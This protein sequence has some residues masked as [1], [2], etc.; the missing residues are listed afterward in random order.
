MTPRELRAAWDEAADTL[1]P[2]L[3]A[4]GFSRSGR[5]WRKRDRASGRIVY[6]FVTRTLRKNTVDLDVSGCGEIPCTL[7]G[8]AS[9]GMLSVDVPSWQR[10]LASADEIPEFR[11]Q[12]SL[13]LLEE[14][15]PALGGILSGNKDKDF[16]DEIRELEENLATTIAVEISDAMRNHLRKQSRGN[17]DYVE[18][19]LEERSIPELLMEALCV[20]QAEDKDSSK[21]AE[22]GQLE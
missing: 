3:S 10:V 2:E 17:N 12:L 11:D 20:D 6:V 1:T 7:W 15:L 5:G 22:N 21:A 19:E 16:C 13:Y 9:M 18:I 4:Q 14:L 8:R